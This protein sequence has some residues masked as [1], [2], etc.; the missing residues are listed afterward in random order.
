MPVYM[1]EIIFSAIIALA[2]FFL[3]Y[4]IN[5]KDDLD[6]IR[7]KSLKESIDCFRLKNK[8][9]HERLE[10]ILLSHAHVVSCENKDCRITLGD[11]TVH[12]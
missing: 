6:D 5:K 12:K 9:E 10:S 1:S 3:K 11:I 8:S 2:F 4:L 7:F